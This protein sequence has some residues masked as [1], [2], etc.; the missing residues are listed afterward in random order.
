MRSL[1]YFISL[2]LDGGNV[3]ESYVRSVAPA[4]KVHDA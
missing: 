4:P 1:T 2:S 3:V